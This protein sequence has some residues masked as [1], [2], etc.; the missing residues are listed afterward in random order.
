M[1]AG[2]ESRERILEAAEELLRRFGPEKFRIVDVAQAL[3]M[4]H[5]NIYRYF[6]DK[7]AILDKIAQRWLAKI[8]GPLQEIVSGR[9]ATAAT[10]LE[11][12]VLTLMR[13]KRRKATADPELFRT[14]QAIAEA[15]R[16]VVAEHIRHLIAQLA[17]IIRNGT[18]AGEWNVRS[19]TKAAEAILNATTF[20]HHPAFVSRPG[21][22]PTEASALDT[23][24][25]L[26]AGLKSGVV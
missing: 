19:P 18:E 20:L 8:T 25:L 4:S 11:E 23:L 16:D 2:E 5:G 22:Q 14:Y 15:S 6:S 3:G 7:E 9:T 21:P 13:L 1:A 12:W 10:R 24:K 26:I 17:E